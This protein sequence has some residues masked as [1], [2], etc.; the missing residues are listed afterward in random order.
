MWTPISRRGKVALSLALLYLTLLAASTLV[1][2]GLHRADD[3]PPTSPANE[4]S[5]LTSLELAEQGGPPKP[6]GESQSNVRFAY[7]TWSP[8]PDLQAPTL[9]VVLLHGSPG[10]SQAFA[11]LGPA[12]SASGYLALAPDLPGFGSSTRKI[13]DYSIRAHAAYVA[14]WLDQQGHSQV[15]LLG[16][17]LGGGVALELYDQRPDLVASMILVAA[18]GVQELELLGNYHLNHSLHG[19]QLAALKLAQSFVPHFGW[20]DRG[21]LDI[22]YARNFF[23]TDQRPLRAILEQLQVPTLIV[24]GERDFLVPPEAAREHH[25]IVPQS[26]LWMRDDSHFF[27]FTPSKTEEL[28]QRLTHFLGRVERSEAAR[29]SQAS[30]ERI[31]AAAAPFDA[32]SIPPWQGPTLLTIMLLLAVATL[33][34]EDLTCLGAGLLVAQDRIGFAPAV[35]ACLTGITVG[36]MMLFFFGRIFGRPALSVPPLS[37]LVS[38]ERLERSSAWLERRGPIII[39][40]SRFTPGMRLPTYVAAGALKTRFYRFAF[41]FLLAAALWTPAIVG[42]SALL[43]E[44]AIERLEGFQSG[45][46]FALAFLLFMFALLRFVLVPL[47]TWRGRRLLL[48]RFKR[49][50]RYEFW[51]IALLYLPLIPWF[52]WLAWRHRSLTVFTACNPAIPAGGFVGESKRAINDAFAA[53]GRVPRFVMALASEDTADRI[54]K[55]S[56]FRVQEELDWPL[57]LKPDAGQRGQGVAIVRSHD[58]IERYFDTHRGDTLVQEFVPGI[59]LGAFYYRDP[60]SHQEGILS[61]TTKEVPRVLGDGQKTLERLILEHPR[62]AIMAPTYFR[63]AGAALEQVPDAGSVIPLS[64]VGAHSRGTVFLDGEQLRT[65][66]LEAAIKALAESCEGF[67]FGRFDLMFPSE[68]AVRKGGPFQM[69]ELN[70]VTA[71]STNLYDPKYQFRDAYRIL[72]QQWSLAFKIGAARRDLGHPTTGPLALVR[73][74][75][76][77]KRR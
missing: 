31:A 58:E 41:Y 61:L 10:N 38:P 39:A 67:D 59:E 32:K 53:S 34:S 68:A 69:I 2:M 11:A 6:G 23:D 62:G 49:L 37:F 5:T 72:A 36:D 73:M 30:P 13:V 15:H 55:A 50:A 19:L 60:K 66:E 70:G 26:E 4:L 76:D 43:G 25:R 9:P 56:Q 54:Q 21:M 24:H 63:E 12:L 33:V 47:L 29:R 35:L 71:E 27:V 8:P 48:G 7:R 18:V 74:W 42:L 52:A 3:T 20:L 75:L 44:A 77:F 17:S 22:S 45:L 65:P 1:R 46:L 40:L 28:N 57:V 16:F 51:P 64:T 14:D